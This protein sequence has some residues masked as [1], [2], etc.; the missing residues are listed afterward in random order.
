M[1]ELYSDVCKVLFHMEY[2]IGSRCQNYN[3]FSESDTFFR[4]PVQVY[5]AYENKMVVRKDIIT[6]KRFITSMGVKRMTY[7]FGKN[8]FHVGEALIEMIDRLELHYR[9][10]RFYLDKEEYKYRKNRKGK[11]NGNE[12]V[13]RSID[14]SN[15]RVC[16]TILKLEYI[17]AHRCYSFNS[18]RNDIIRYRYPVRYIKDGKIKKVTYD[19]LGKT[20]CDEEIIKSLHYSLGFNTIYIG[21]ALIDILEYISNRY[22]IDLSY[23]EDNF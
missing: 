2:L 13:T 23:F 7:T 17:F 9:R 18:M 16:M 4:Y 1:S 15:P 10:H 21:K 3:Y 5:D 14:L 6:D 11:K 12:K 20:C 8:N 19:R 22:D